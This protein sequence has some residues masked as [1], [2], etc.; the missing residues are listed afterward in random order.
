MCTWLVSNL[1]LTIDLPQSYRCTSWLAR[2]Q[3]GNLLVQWPS[4]RGVGARPACMQRIARLPR[5]SHSGSHG[6]LSVRSTPQKELA[7]LLVISAQVGTNGLPPHCANCSKPL[8]PF[9][10]KTSYEASLPLIS[11][12]QG[13][14]TGARDLTLISAASTSFGRYNFGLDEGETLSY[15]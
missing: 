12:V 3:V 6:W 10:I 4:D 13:P 11:H 9:S 7:T 5:F 2:L 1:M 15:L 14:P 8:I